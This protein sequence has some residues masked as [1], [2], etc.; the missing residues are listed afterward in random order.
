M[1]KRGLEMLELLSGSRP[2]GRISPAVFWVFSS[3]FYRHFLRPI[4][5][6]YT[7]AFWNLHARFGWLLRLQEP[8]FMYDYLLKWVLTE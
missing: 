8:F 4:M 2:V 7:Q 1:W 5:T 3:R 6:V